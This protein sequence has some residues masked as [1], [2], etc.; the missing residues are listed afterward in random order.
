MPLTRRVSQVR[1][2]PSV[3]RRVRSAELTSA[4]Q[5]DILDSFSGRRES[6][7]Y[8]TRST[9][10]GTA[11]LPTL[12]PEHTVTVKAGVDYR[13]AYPVGCA[14]V[15]NRFPRRLERSVVND[16]ESAGRELRI[17]R[18]QCLPRGFIQITIQTHDGKF[19]YACCRKRIFE[20]PLQED[21][22]VVE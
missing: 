7:G 18:R 4:T 2:A 17:Q 11:R 9:L 8:A 13:I 21:D 14:V 16:T 19:F 20:P 6:P 15:L 5:V 22:V 3:K 10:S 12:S 1:V